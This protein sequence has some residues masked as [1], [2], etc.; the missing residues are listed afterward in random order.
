MPTK[1]KFS[2]KSVFLI[3]FWGTFTPFFKDKKS[4]RSHNIVE[5]KV[6]LLLW[7]VDVRITDLGGPNTYGSGC[8]TLANRMFLT[9]ERSADSPVP[10]PLHALV[11][12]QPLTKLW[13]TEHHH[14]NSANVNSLGTLIK[15]KIYFF[16]SIRK[17]RWDRVQSHI[18]VHHIWRGRYIVIYNWPL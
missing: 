15:K 14:N 5:I 2:L 6:F 4:K 11:G 17:F 18:G 7:L 8:T 12:A 1:N 3:T 13:S 10:A 9:L 16:S